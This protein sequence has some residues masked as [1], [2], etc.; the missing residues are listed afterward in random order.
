MSLIFR[1]STESLFSFIITTAPFQSIDYNI[2]N[3][4]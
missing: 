4:G 3:F 1:I 2:N